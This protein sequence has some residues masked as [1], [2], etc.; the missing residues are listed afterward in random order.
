MRIYSPRDVS[1]YFDQCFN[2]TTLAIQHTINLAIILG[3]IVWQLKQAKLSA[4]VATPLPHLN[5]ADILAALET[6]QLIVTLKWRGG[7]EGRSTT[8]L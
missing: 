1:K 4:S 5:V 7:G 6:L 2:K 8:K 3:K